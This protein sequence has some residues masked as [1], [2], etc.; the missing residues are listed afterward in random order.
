MSYISDYLNPLSYLPC[1]ATFIAEGLTIMKMG[2]DATATTD[3]VRVAA[4]VTAGAFIGSWSFT[5]AAACFAD[6]K[7]RAAGYCAIGFAGL[8]FSVV[9]LDRACE[10]FLTRG[11]ISI[12]NKYGSSLTRTSPCHPTLYRIVN[13]ACGQCT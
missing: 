4:F 2:L 11:C 1:D 12:I 3:L 13:A 10:F 8:T 6:S 5:T 7:K 9:T